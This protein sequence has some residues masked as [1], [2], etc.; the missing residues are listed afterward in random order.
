[1]FPTVSTFCLAFTILLSPLLDAFWF[2]RVKVRKMG[3]KNY[4]VDVWC[5]RK[6]IWR[7]RKRGNT[8]RKLQFGQVFAIKINQNAQKFGRGVPFSLFDKLEICPISVIKWKATPLVRP[9]WKKFNRFRSKVSKRSQMYCRDQF[10][11]EEICPISVKCKGWYD[12]RELENVQN[13]TDFGQKNIG[14]MLIPFFS[15]I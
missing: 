7:C 14:A 15:I 12:R 4:Q 2:N 10:F 3:L 8:V 9:T 11:N 6:W 1:M 13:L 5:V